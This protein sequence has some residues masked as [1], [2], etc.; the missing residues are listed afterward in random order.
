MT[1]LA[2]NFLLVSTM[3][4]RQLSGG[5][6]VLPASEV[7]STATTRTAGAVAFA[8]STRSTV[9]PAVGGGRR[10]RRYGSQSDDPGRMTGP[11]RPPARQCRVRRPGIGTDGGTG[12]DRAPLLALGTMS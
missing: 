11:D 6:R 8:S 12:S 9:H 10:L 4:L 5:R 2:C 1:L 7:V 3:L